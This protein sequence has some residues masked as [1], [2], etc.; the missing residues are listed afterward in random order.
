MNLAFVFFVFAV[1]SLIHIGLDSIFVDT[2]MPLYPFSDY[3]I[4]LEMVSKVR[5]DLQELVLPIVDAILLFFWIFWM[6]FKL[7]I[8]DYF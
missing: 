7:K 1:G 8:D 3:A 2:L 4:G 6:Q 5:L